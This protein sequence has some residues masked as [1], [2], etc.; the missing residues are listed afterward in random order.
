MSTIDSAEL[1]SMAL[2][3]MGVTSAGNPANAEDTEKVTDMIP[4][5]TEELSARGI[6]TVATVE[7]I[8]EEW[9]GALSQLLANYCAAI[10]G[11]PRKPIQEVMDAEDR[12]RVMVQRH[13]AS[14]ETLR[15]DTA[16]HPSRVGYA[17]ANWLRGR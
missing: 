13:Q 4:R 16:L 12:L 7:E 11:L 5:L 8:P 1:A 9:A 3:E 6:C 14:R 17:Y 15:V 2:D 10:F